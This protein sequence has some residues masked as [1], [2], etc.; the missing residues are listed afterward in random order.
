MQ[1][2][3][4]ND[5][6]E[7]GLYFLKEDDV[8][9]LYIGK[10][11]GGRLSKS[12][13]EAKKSIKIVSPFLGKAEVEKLRE[14]KLGGLQDIAV[15]AK[16]SD[17]TLNN[18]PQV[19]A[20]KG[21]IHQEK[22]K[23]TSEYVYTAIFES[24]F[25]DGDFLHEKLYIIDNEIAYVGSVNFTLKGMTTNHETCLTVKE[26]DTVN[27]LSDYFDRLFKANLKKWKIADLGKR[28]Y[29]YESRRKTK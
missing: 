3:Q 17:T 24:I 2:S 7:K 21:L 14:K 18:P 26:P 9:N 5:S 27:G 11:A 29:S 12:I 4:K 13:L 8:F 6:P 19:A 28:I 10:N 16:V 23:N 22:Q 20:L 1:D 25:F 15:I